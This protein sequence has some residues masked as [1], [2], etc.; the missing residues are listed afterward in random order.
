M[1]V[2]DTKM[3]KIEKKGKGKDDKRKVRKKIRVKR[4]KKKYVQR[5]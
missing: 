5:K 3:K 4:V 2:A 1:K